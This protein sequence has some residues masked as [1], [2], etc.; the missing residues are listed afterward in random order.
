[1]ENFLQGRESLD[2]VSKTPDTI[3]CRRGT[4]NASRDLRRGQG[5]F[6][7]STWSD[8]ALPGCEVP[9]RAGGTASQE[10]GARRQARVRIFFSGDSPLF[11]GLVEA[12][13]PTVTAQASP[14]RRFTK[15]PARGRSLTCRRVLRPSSAKQERPTQPAQGLRHRRSLRRNQKHPAPHTRGSRSPEPVLASGA[16][17]RAALPRPPPPGAPRALPARLPLS[18]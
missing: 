9:P 8:R 4:K 3:R 13:A 11:T 12:G 6:R 10:D 5:A 17:P 16:P 2:H 7:L 14:A 18:L 15:S 1:M